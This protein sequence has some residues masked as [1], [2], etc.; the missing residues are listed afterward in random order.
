MRLTRLLLVFGSL[1][2][3]AGMTALL[4]VQPACSPG[5]C[6]QSRIDPNTPSSALECAAGL[7][8]YQGQCIKACNAG[9]EGAQQCGGDGDCDGTRPHCIDGYCSACDN[10]EFCVP[11][12]NICQAVSEIDLTMIPVPPPPPTGAPKPP[13]PLDGGWIDGGL[14]LDKDAGEDVPVDAVVTHAGLV[15]V[16]QIE[17]YFTNGTLTKKSKVLVR[18]HYVGGVTEPGLIWRVDPWDDVGGGYDP[19]TETA[20]EEA[21]G[22]DCT[23]NYLRTYTGTITLPQ[24]DLGDVVVED[25]PGFAGSISNHFDV[26]WDDVND[27]GYAAPAPTPPPANLLVFSKLLPQSEPHFISIAA[28]QSGLAGAWPNPTPE[29]GEHVPFELVPS[30]DTLTMLTSG[31]TLDLA[32]PADLVV[33]WDRIAAGSVNGE[34]VVLRFRGPNYEVH[35][36]KTEGL[37]VDGAI[38]VKAGLLRSFIMHQGVTP[39]TTIPLYFERRFARRTDV[40]PTDPTTEVIDL[41]VRVRHTLVGTLRFQ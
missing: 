6:T 11:T 1:T 28:T 4:L 31:V 33:R 13:A 19:A 8:C 5:Q 36:E 39:G 9:Q 27:D 15:D 41:S 2:F 29:N 30:A 40:I 38:I 7:L 3:A 18:M 10:N 14:R 12:L 22:E 20:I 25:A 17:D 35:C 34:A 26:P 21:L 16:A 32:T 37:M 24:V 23:L